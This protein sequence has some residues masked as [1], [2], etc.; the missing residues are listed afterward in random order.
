MGL[1][2]AEKALY[3]FSS[4]NQICNISEQVAHLIEERRA[5]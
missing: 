1:E 5:S 4:A 2:K 3:D